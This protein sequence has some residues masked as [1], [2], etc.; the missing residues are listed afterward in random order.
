MFAILIMVMGFPGVY[1]STHQTVHFKHLHVTVHQL[2]LDKTENKQ[3]GSVSFLPTHPTLKMPYLHF[4][5]S[6]TVF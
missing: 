6:G 1:M 5:L 4:Q 3:K 2:N